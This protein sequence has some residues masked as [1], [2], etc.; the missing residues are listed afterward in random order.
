MTG[1]VILPEGLCSVR[2]LLRSAY[3]VL[4]YRVS[5]AL[6]LEYQNACTRCLAGGDMLS[7]STWIVKCTIA[8]VG[9]Q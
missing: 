1:S 9:V 8:S 3:I 6:L 7:W 5:H 2:R 4:D